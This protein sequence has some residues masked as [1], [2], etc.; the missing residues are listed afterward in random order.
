MALKMIDHGTKEYEQM[1]HLRYEILRK[2]IGLS[3]DKNELDKEKDD[4]LIGAFEDER[5]LG[6]CLL[7]KMDDKTVRLRQ[8]AVPNNLQG[9]GIGRA[10]M[11]FAENIARDLGYKKLIMHARKT[12]IGF[13]GKLGYSVVGNE[14][15]EVTIPHFVMEKA[16]RN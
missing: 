5:I 1:V 9:K 10:L 12:A 3:F 4:V 13:Y 8:M 16:L 15:E 7:T 11:I 14:F 6:C 2:P